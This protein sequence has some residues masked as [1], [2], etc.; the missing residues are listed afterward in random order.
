M[1][2]NLSFEQLPQAVTQLTAEIGELKRLLIEQGNPAPTEPTD[3]WFNLSELVAYD[4]AKRSKATWYSKVSRGEVPFHKNGKHL[5][6]LKSEI[7]QW[8][9]EGKQLSNAEIEKRAQAYISNTKKG[10]NNGK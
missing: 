2:E 3:Q 5:V 6:F 8:L 4:P 9:K 7:D 1:K 10:L